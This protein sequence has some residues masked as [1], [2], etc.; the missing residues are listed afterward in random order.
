MKKIIYLPLILILLS[1]CGS[2]KKQNSIP[3]VDVTKTYPKKEIV[4]QDIADVEYIP[5]ETR[6]DVLLGSRA[7]IDYISKDLIVV[8]NRKEGDIFVFNGKGKLLSKFNHKGQGANEYTRISSVVYAPS[9]KEIFVKNRKR[10]LI[11]NTAGQF[12]REIEVKAKE[13]LGRICN[14]NKDN[15]IAYEIPNYSMDGSLNI[16][17][18]K[19]KVPVRNKTPMFFISKQTG[20]IDTLK[21]FYIPKRNPDAIFHFI[22]GGFSI[23]SFTTNYITKVANGFVL[24]NFYCDTIFHLN[25][26]RKLTPI[27]IKQP[28]YKS[29]DEN[30]L[31]VNVISVSP[32]YC[33]FKIVKRV[34]EPGNKI[35][36]TV[37]VN[38]KNHDIVE[39]TLRNKEIADKEFKIKPFSKLLNADD[40]LDLLEK[41]KLSGQLKTIAENLK[42]EDNPVIIKVT[43]R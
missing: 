5:L 15:I 20:V 43:L 35:K 8:S 19:K 41:G 12:Q 18:L 38:R 1:S 3:T 29:L 6:D 13:S 32:S 25:Q 21:A 16:N 10:F 37:C 40:L 24:D 42:E 11:Y 4:L 27:L 39:Y 31:V 23:Y 7:H 2:E 14:F 9:T 26:Q 34:A 17:D 30:P 36:A 33:F 22:N 28:A